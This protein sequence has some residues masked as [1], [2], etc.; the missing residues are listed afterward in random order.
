MAPPFLPSHSL[1]ADGTFA[2]WAVFGA[3]D[4]EP[5]P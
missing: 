1:S 5:R 3:S 2:A 4:K